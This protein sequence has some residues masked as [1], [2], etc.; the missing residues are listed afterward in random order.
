MKATQF[1]KGVVTKPTRLLYSSRP[2]KICN[3]FV[4][5]DRKWIGD[6]DIVRACHL[7]SKHRI[8][9]SP[10]V[11][12][13]RKPGSD[14]CS[15][16]LS[17]DCNIGSPDVE[18]R[19]AV[20]EDEA[21]SSAGKDV[22]PELT[23]TPVSKSQSQDVK[24]E[25]LMLS[26]PAAAGQ[27]L[28]PLAQ[29]METAYIGRLVGGCLEGMTNGK[30][31]NG[32]AERKQL[33]SVSTALL[34][35]VVIGIIEALA[36]YFGAGKFLDLMG[37]S[38]DSSM[39]IPAQRFLSL[40]AFGAPAV[41]VSLAL[42]GVFRG[43]KDTK[44]P[45]LCLGIGNLLAVFLFPILMYYFQLGATG[46]AISTVLS[47]YT[48][49]FLLI[50]KL[51]KIAVLLPPKMGSLQFG[52]YIKSGGFLLGRTLAVLT[53]MTLGTSMAARQG[54]V[55]MAAHQICIQV[56]LAVS[57]LID[58]L[59]ASGQALIASSL[60]K[61]EYK[62]VKDIT[63][64]VL[65]IGL[66]TGVFLSAI[67]GV[68]FGSLAT[69]FTKDPEVLGI[70]KTG[71]LFVS[72]SQPLTALAYVFDGLHYGVSDFAY[73]ARS[74]M[75]VGT[76]CSA[77]LLYVPSIVGLPGV[78]LGLTL[79]MG[80]RMVAG[81]VRLLSKSGPWWFLHRDFQRTEMAT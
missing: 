6:A 10:L 51:N 31:S 50:W 22:I 67:L 80:L 13:R 34:L 65:K 45:V 16:Q 60:S 72:A 47:Q 19:L 35:A 70:V 7:F 76:I 39:R 28:E 18:E 42:Q 61:G 26:L 64:F 81:C 21:L 25:L 59:A 68:S 41:V 29:L 11:T 20:E 53:T 5:V 57:L 9:L 66:F 12:R 69:L 52:G 63:F 43:F 33:S 77:F 75:L 58:A 49:T 78:W 27:A 44:T 79:F 74:M 36:L 62:T 38:S 73:A 8:R 71:V 56:W 24:H 55:A 15:C 40:R 17:S 30:P 3:F 14:A 37:I 4:P 48:V 54:P 23:G 2:S 1:S 32:V 46:A